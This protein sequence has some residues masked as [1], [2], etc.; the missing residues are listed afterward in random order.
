MKK[1]FAFILIVCLLTTVAFA[2]ACAPTRRSGNSSFSGSG[3]SDA[4]SSENGDDTGDSGS[5]ENL[6]KYTDLML[7]YEIGSVAARDLDG[8]FTLA[9]NTFAADLYKSLYDGKNELISPLSIEIALA[10]TANGA[11]GDTKTQM[12]NVLFSGYGIGAFNEYYLNYVKSLYLS[13]GASIGIANFVW[14]KDDENFSVKKEFLRTNA[15]YYGAQAYKAPFDETT[16]AEINGWV[17]RKTDG[18][19]DKIIEEI[20]KDALMYLINA[21]SF[22]AKWLEQFETSYPDKFTRSDG[23]VTNVD[24]MPG[25]LRGYLHNDYAEGFK[26]AYED[27]RFA[28]CV[29]LPYDGVSVYDVVTSL[30]GQALTDYFNSS[31]N[32]KVALK[33]PKF[34]LDFSADLNEDLKSLGMTDAFDPYIA[35]FS[36]L[37]SYMGENLYISF[38]KHKTAIEVTEAGTKAAAVT[39]VGIEKATSIGTPEKTHYIFLNRPFIYFILDTATNTPLFMGAYEG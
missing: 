19:I 2:T 25:E 32:E 10:M 37:G 29:M 38:V 39:A 5:G 35:D 6:P 3:E 28:F 34:R 13:E 33:M 14:F 1:F 18:M 21:V 30:S 31:V 23:S 15:D 17:K 12:E 9:Y 8:D 22:D 11:S 20:S 4:S 16:L 24:M 27:G 7:G 36:G 26:K